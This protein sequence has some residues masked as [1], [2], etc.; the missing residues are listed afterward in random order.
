M[1]LQECLKSF[2]WQR[3]GTEEVNGLSSGEIRAMLETSAR[4]RIESELSR[5]LD[6]KPK[7]AVLWL[8]KE[9]R[10]KSRT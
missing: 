2:G 6:T 3:V 8:L 4:R 7:L 9:R 10:I 1:K 5:E